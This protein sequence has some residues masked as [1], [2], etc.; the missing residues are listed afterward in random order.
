MW[1]K[2]PNKEIEAVVRYAE[3]K[4]WQVV[5]RQ[6]HAWGIL[7][8]PHNRNDCRCGLFCQISVW[9]TPKNPEI[10]ARQLRRKI[11]GCK[12]DQGKADE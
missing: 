9:S 3:L 10:H 7:R 12:Y 2:H 1:K 11:D 4:G 8:C 6:G 5:E